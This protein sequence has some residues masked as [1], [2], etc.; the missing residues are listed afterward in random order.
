MFNVVVSVT[1]LN[2]SREVGE[3]LRGIDIARQAH[4]IVPQHMLAGAVTSLG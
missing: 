3:G 1:D 2:D 4:D